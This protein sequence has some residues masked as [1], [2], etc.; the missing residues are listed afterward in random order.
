MKKT[1]WF[2]ADIDP[3]HVGEYECVRFG[4]MCE[5]FGVHRLHWNGEKW[6]YVQALGM[7]SAG[8]FALM[9]GSSGDKW[10]GL[11]RDAA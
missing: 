6:T 2:D 7:S 5:Q 9:L 8:D 10:R 4:G 1:E 3:V 11:A